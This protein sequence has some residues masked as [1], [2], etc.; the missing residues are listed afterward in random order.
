MRSSRAIVCLGFVAA[1]ACAC[2]GA[3]SDATTDG[4]SGGDATSS[5][6][7]WSEPACLT[8]TPC[9]T[10]A[11]CFYAYYCSLDSCSPPKGK[12]RHK[13]EGLGWCPPAGEKCDAG[14]GDTDTGLGE[15]WS[16]PPCSTDI[17]CS[18]NADCPY[19]YYCALDSC[20]PPT[21]LCRHQVEDG[22]WCIPA[23]MDCDA[24]VA[25]SDTGACPVDV[26][27]GG[28]PCAPLGLAC[29]YPDPSVTYPEC[30]AGVSWV[31]A[32]CN[33]GGWSISFTCR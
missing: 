18:T 3:V 14:V 10:D 9:S 17:A 25:D 28:A 27:T 23:G 16:E 12:C 29:D 13:M 31:G 8:G 15:T 5:Q 2:G 32:L 20:S 4:G 7:N 30:E 22:T 21:G 33:P 11:D 19:S 6:E 1:L 26:P 24:G